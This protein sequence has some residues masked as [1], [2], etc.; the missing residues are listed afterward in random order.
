[1][2]D[3]LGEARVSNSGY[4]FGVKRTRI[5]QASVVS[6]VLWLR[7]SSVTD[8]SLCPCRVFFPEGKGLDINLDPIGF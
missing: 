4:S 7:T 6:G 3:P 2:I 1:M 8:E 5:Y